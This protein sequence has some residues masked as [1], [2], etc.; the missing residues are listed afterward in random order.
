MRRDALGKSGGEPLADG[1]EPGV[2]RANLSGALD[3]APTEG[4]GGP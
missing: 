2:G 1:E 4:E 3:G